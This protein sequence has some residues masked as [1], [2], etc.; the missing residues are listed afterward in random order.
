MKTIRLFFAIV[1]PSLLLACASIPKEAPEL[2]AEL[3]KRL[4]AIESSHI[5]LLNQFFNTKRQA[6]D[7]FIEEEWMPTFTE[8]FFSNPKIKTAWDTVVRE[9]DKQERLNFLLFT[10]PKL[11]KALYQK[12]K[13]L[14]EPLNELEKMIAKTI[15]AEYA[16]ANAINNS[17]TSLLYFAAK[18]DDNR[19]RYLAMLGVSDQKVSNALTKTDEVVA[20]YLQKSNT[21]S[22]KS[23]KIKSI[24]NQL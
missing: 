1:I 10:G 21:V 5:T 23:E 16:Q 2:S 6:V 15:R 17:V 11:Q 12:K 20:E 4:S 7:E 14:I 3:G 19:E 13:E 24:K 22:E 8:N 18:I 9:N